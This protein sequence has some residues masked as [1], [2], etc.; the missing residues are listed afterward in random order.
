MDSAH[1][2]AP[3]AVVKAQR[4]LLVVPGCARYHVCADCHVDVWSRVAFI[5]GPGG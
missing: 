4:V 5:T 2:K 1:K 3:R